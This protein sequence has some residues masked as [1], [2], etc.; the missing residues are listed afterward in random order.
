MSLLL[1]LSQVEFSALDM[2]LYL[3]THPHDKKAIALYNAFTS[4]AKTLR[5]EYEKC[6][7]PLF[8]YI[9]KSREDYFSWIDEPWPWQKEFNF[10]ERNCVDI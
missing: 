6:Y 2:Q 1:K 9:S 10:K 7:G 5:E 8:S 3:D 4:E